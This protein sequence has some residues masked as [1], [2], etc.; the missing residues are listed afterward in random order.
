MSQ[1][2]FTVRVYFNVKKT[3]NDH[4]PSFHLKIISCFNSL[5]IIIIIVVLVV[6]SVVVSIIIIF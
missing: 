4:S 6:V 5:I 3:K 2:C 1:G